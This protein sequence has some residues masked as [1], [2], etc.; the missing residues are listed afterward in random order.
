MFNT[1]LQC[2]TSVKF[3]AFTDFS[4]EMA[5]RI[6]R[7]V[8]FS[9]EFQKTSVNKFAEFL[10]KTCPSWSQSQTELK[11]VEPTD[12]KSRTTLITSAK[13]VDG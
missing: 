4:A 1:D 2:S 12:S 7:V 11:L 9:E 10:K 3:K 13:Y 5:S 8:I 6:V